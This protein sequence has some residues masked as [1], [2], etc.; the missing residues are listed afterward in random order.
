MS[1]VARHS[2]RLGVF[3]VAEY[4]LTSHRFTTDTR[5]IGISGQIINSKMT[6]CLIGTQVSPS[7]SHEYCRE[8]EVRC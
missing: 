5:S 3:V 1:Q 6:D 4:P 8:S 7:L 2:P